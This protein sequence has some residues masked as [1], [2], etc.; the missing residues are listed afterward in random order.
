MHAYSSRTTETLEI[1]NP[2]RV[3]PVAEMAPKLFE[4]TVE[5]LRAE[6]HAAELKRGGIKA[7]LTGSEEGL[8]ERWGSSAVLLKTGELV[9]VMDNVTAVHVLTFELGASPQASCQN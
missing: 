6:T 2:S 8:N 5:A 3:A 9:K 7:L 4:S 1:L